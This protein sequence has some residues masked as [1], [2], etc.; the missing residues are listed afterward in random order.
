MHAGFIVGWVKTRRSNVEFRSLNPTYTIPVA[1][2]GFWQGS[3][4]NTTGAWLEADLSIKSITWDYGGYLWHGEINWPG[5]G[6]F[7]RA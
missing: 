5:S 1:V 3:K 6:G 7:C 2:A 4:P